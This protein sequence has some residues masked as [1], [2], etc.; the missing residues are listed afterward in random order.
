VKH[1]SGDIPIA[2]RFS[3]PEFRQGEATLFALFKS[4][5]VAPEELPTDIA[6]RVQKDKKRMALVCE[7]ILAERECCPF[8]TLPGDFV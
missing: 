2:C 8:L 3:D 4:A 6:L 1:E 5:V 7:L